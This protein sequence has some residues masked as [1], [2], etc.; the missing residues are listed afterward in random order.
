MPYN[1]SRMIR[2][3]FAILMP[4]CPF[5][6]HAGD[7]IFKVQLLLGETSFPT[8]MGW[9]SPPTS[10]L[11]SITNQ[12]GT[13]M[14]MTYVMPD[15]YTADFSHSTCGNTLQAGESCQLA[16]RFN[17]AKVGRF[18]GAIK[19]CGQNNLW[20][21]NDPIGFDVTV[22]PNTIISTQCG[23]IQSRPFAVL[24]CEGSFQYAQNFY[25]LIARTLNTTLSTTAQ[26]FNY[27]QHTPSPNETTTNCLTAKQT[28]ITLDP[29]ITGGGASLCTLMGYATS[30]SGSQ[31]AVSKLF[32]PYLTQLL[33]TSYPITDSTEVL[34]NL[35]QLLT[36]FD[37]PAMDSLVRDVGYTGYVDFLNTYY[38]QQSTVPYSDCGV[39]PH[40]ACPS[41]YYLPYQKE[42]T[43]LTTWPP[44]GN[45][46]WGASGGGGS[47]AGYQ[48]EAFM[49]HSTTHF[50]LFSGGG[51]GGG[52]NTTPEGLHTPVIDL[53]N[54][55]SGGG[56]GSQ[57]ANCYTNNAQDSLNGLGLGAGTGSGLSTP[58]GHDVTFQPPPP[59]DYSYLPPNTT[60][61]MPHSIILNQYGTNLTYLFHTL[62]P[63]L[64]NAGYTITITGGGGGG[65]GLE[66]L[67]NEGSEYLPQ[68]VSI[69]Y[70]FN[71]CYVFNKNKIY[72][73]SD[74]ISSPNAGSSGLALD[75]IIYQNLGNF[76]NQGMSLAVEHFKGYT[77]YVQ[78]CTFQHAYVICE[79]T[80]LLYANH[81]TSADI[82]TWLIN[83]HCNDTQQE[84]ITHAALVDALLQADQA[85]TPDCTTAIQNFYQTQASACTLPT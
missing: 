44:A 12:S 82:P 40:A 66:F 5:L 31:G 57:F 67:N 63:Q 56:G 48:I 60:P 80:N 27:F 59:V 6:A 32:P 39:P 35:A 46:Y 64:Y 16:V 62:I 49:P 26:H 13:P 74:C 70:G 28:G 55:G 52:G 9:F 17:P 8:S 36:Q 61:L 81:Y 65:A 24:D 75:S 45:D 21:S 14:P 77:D 58:E 43:L 18:M 42:A 1:V 15:P 20:C 51:G 73:D 23:T 11:M 29:N 53:I 33:G 79:L 83:P 47:G 25:S 30:N 50:T 10:R 71:F 72:T 69:G 37:T 19:V 84:V 34:D 7:P 78:I 76:F 54:T 68:P 2:C 38:L 4:L 85:N 22:V 3:L 41:I